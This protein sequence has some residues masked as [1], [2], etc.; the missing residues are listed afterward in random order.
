MDT[1]IKQAL[2][3]LLD[4][5]NNAVDLLQIWLAPKYYLVQHAASLI[6]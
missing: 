3:E 1:E 5:I 4:K 6:H 2:S